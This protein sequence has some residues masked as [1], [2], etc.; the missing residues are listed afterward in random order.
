[1]L[2]DSPGTPLLCRR[3]WGLRGGLLLRWRQRTRE[4]IHRDPAIEHHGGRFIQSRAETIKIID[5]GIRKCTGETSSVSHCRGTPAY[6]AP[7]NR[8]SGATTSKVDVYSLG[9]MLFGNAVWE[10]DVSYAGTESCPTSTL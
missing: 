6:M 7:E 2:A 8:Y 4:I 3:R 9:C 5:F 10:S 1:M